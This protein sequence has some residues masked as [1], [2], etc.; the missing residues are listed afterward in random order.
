MPVVLFQRSSAP[1]VGRRGPS[2]RHPQGKRWFQSAQMQALRRL[3]NLAGLR[4]QVEGS[5]DNLWI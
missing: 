1:D 5:N 2:R 4:L 3:R